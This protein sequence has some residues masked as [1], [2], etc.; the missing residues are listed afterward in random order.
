MQNYSAGEWLAY[1]ALQNAGVPDPD[2]LI[3]FLHAADV[4]LADRKA[5]QMVCRWVP[6]SDRAVPPEADTLIRTITRTHGEQAWVT[7]YWL[8]GLRS[9]VD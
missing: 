2:L 4:G 9:P 8:E 3:A 7:S 1:Q 6:V 5:G